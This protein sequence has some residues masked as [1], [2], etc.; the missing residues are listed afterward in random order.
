VARIRSRIVATSM[1]ISLVTWLQACVIVP[2][3][4][5]K[6]LTEERLSQLVVGATTRDEVNAIFGDEYF[7]D[8]G[9]SGVVYSKDRL[10]AFGVSAWGAGGF[11]A[12]ENLYVEFDD[13]NFLT[14]YEQFEF[15]DGKACVETG[16][17][18]I[19]DIRG[20]IKILRSV[21]FISPP[22]EDLQAKQ[23][24]PPVG[25]CSVYLYGDVSLK[26][27]YRLAGATNRVCLNGQ[28][29]AELYSPDLYLKLDLAPGAYQFSV[30]NAIAWHY[31]NGLGFNRQG[32]DLRTAFRALVCEP[33]TVHFLRFE[34]RSELEGLF[35]EKYK[36]SDIALTMVDE[37]T[38]KA[39]VTARS[40]SSDALNAWLYQSAGNTNKAESGVVCDEA[41][42]TE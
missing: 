25:R 5:K 36:F 39:A 24:K 7:S 33:D 1:T 19:G 34:E 10:I 4:N 14:H 41:N 22:D 31:A 23:F 35:V 32:E 9:G 29:T 18:M 30:G 42:Q 28:F 8:P 27:T 21:A 40:L 17:C 15:V 3:P 6:L 26:A 37:Q 16:V 11:E 12:A 38:G 20:D 13:E 2:I